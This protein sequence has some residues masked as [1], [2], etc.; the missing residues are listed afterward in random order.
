MKNRKVY[1]KGI[2]SFFLMVAVAVNWGMAANAGIQKF[3]AKTINHLRTGNV[4][5]ALQEYMVGEDGDRIE[6]LYRDEVLPGTYVSKIPSIQNLSSACYIRVKIDYKSILNLKDESLK[7]ISEEWIKKGDY[8]YYCPILNEGEEVD[9]FTGIQFPPEWDE[10][11]ANQE[12]NMVLQAEAIQA[13]NFNPDYG[14]E[15]PWFGQEAQYCL[16]EYGVKA[17]GGGNG[18]MYVI[19]ENQLEVRPRDFFENMGHLMPGDTFQDTF[20]IKNK[21][22]E[23]VQIWFRTKLPELSEKQKELLEKTGLSIWIGETLLYQGNLASHELEE[24]IDMGQVSKKGEKKV[25]FSVSV[26][27]EWDN[28]YALCDT[29]IH[30]IFDTE[31]MVS[32]PSPSTGDED[33]GWF[34]LIMGG[35]S[36]FLLLTILC[37]KKWKDLR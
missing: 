1:V 14:T 4:K 37:G 32:D 21:N 30:W 2:V 8:W 19:F 31:R 35:I 15:D 33:N 11:Q 13:Q 12:I 29:V 34:F 23:N 28:T 26:P 18:P 5:I 20:T 17:G 27:K 24:G 9:F 3:Q 36:F 10:R 16:Q 6:F 25:S 7:G 22:S